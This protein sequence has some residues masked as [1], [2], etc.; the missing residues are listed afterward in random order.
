ME[1]VEMEKFKALLLE[2]KARIQ[3][4]AILTS[5]DDL[6]I[7]SDDLADESDIAS[8]VINQ[9]VSMNMRHRELNKL[10]LINEALYRIDNGGYGHCEECEET[11]G[12]KRL[13]NQPWATLCITHAEEHE[14]LQG[15]RAV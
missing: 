11:I 2:H 6:H 10:R 8:N 9:H 3:N 12:M 5:K 1:K 13:Q 14:R 7:S 4:G 15:Q